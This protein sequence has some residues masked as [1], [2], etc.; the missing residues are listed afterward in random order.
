MMSEEIL[1]IGVLLPRQERTFG[2]WAWLA[3]GG[4]WFLFHLAFGWRMLILLL[5]ILVI[6]PYVVQRR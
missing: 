2:R 1:C 4:G 3:N 6:E 5:P